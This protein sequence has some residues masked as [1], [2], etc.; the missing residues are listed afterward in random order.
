ML[1]VFA[2]NKGKDPQNAVREKTSSIRKEK[3]LPNS[4]YLPSTHLGTGGSEANKFPSVKSAR[5]LLKT[6]RHIHR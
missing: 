3:N 4:S 2:I 5:R 1:V 6:N